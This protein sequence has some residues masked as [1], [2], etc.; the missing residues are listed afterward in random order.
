MW[1]HDPWSAQDM[2]T[3]SK[4]CSPVLD[5]FRN[6]PLFADLKKTH[7]GV[8]RRPRHPQISNCADGLFNICHFSVG[9]F[10]TVNE[11]EYWNW[12]LTRPLSKC[13]S[14]LGVKIFDNCTLNCYQG[15]CHCGV[16][17]SWSFL[18][19]DAQRFLGFNPNGDC[20]QRKE[21]SNA[22]NAEHAYMSEPVKL[23]YLWMLI[24]DGGNP[25]WG[26]GRG[27]SSED[28]LSELSPAWPGEWLSHR[29]WSGVENIWK[30]TRSRSAQLAW[31]EVHKSSLY[32]GTEKLHMIRNFS[33]FSCSHDWSC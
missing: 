32:D 10:C 12:H 30:N 15:W 7:F 28:V 33:E 25:K 11:E 16:R 1:A 31:F 17:G 6:L 26:K 4:K 20:L 24:A 27:S 21:P 13:Y 8:F 2:S 14:T 18:H 5:T 29:C 3:S 9:Y 23:S 19:I 22:E